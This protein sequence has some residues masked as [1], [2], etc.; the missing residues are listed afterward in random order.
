MPRPGYILIYIAIRMFIPSVKL[1]VYP[2][3]YLM[4]IFSTWAEDI[5]IS[6]I[7]IT[8]PTVQLIE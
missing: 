5:G 4:S 2:E 8:A 3:G 7:R 6:W 1:V